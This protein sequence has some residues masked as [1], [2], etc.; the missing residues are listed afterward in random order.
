MTAKR[1]HK[2]MKKKQT[3]VFKFPE[4]RFTKN[5]GFY[6]GLTIIVVIFFIL[7]KLLH[8]SIFSKTDWN[9][10]TL[11]AKAWWQGKYWLKENYSYLELALYKGR[12]F[13]SFPP[14][15]S[16]IIFFLIPFFGMN[17]P[18]NLLTSMYMVL[19]FVFTYKFCRNLGKKDITASFWAVFLVAG[20]NVFAHAVNGGVW[21]QAQSLSFLFSTLSLYFISKQKSKYWHLAFLAWALSVGCRP[22]QIVFVPILLYLLYQNIKKDNVKNLFFQNIFSMVKFSLSP[23]LVGIALAFYNY[24]RFNNPI[25]FGHTYLKEFIE[26]PKGQ[27]NLSYLFENW[28]NIFRLPKIVGGKV[29]FER[30]NGW[31]FYLANPLYILFFLQLVKKIITRPNDVP[32]LVETRIGKQIFLQSKNLLLNRSVIRKISLFDILIFVVLLFHIVVTLMHKTLGGWQFGIR[33][34]A[35][36][37]PFILFYMMYKKDTTGSPFEEKIQVTEATL[38]IIIALIAIALNFYGCLWLFKNWS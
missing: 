12:V 18:D 27:F 6:M 3:S 23:L 30:F 19:S 33:Y 5:I 1:I 34:L 16:V 4:N 21:F 22:L 29:I 32:H 28:H 14:I 10:Y 9:S 13:V 24:L 37:L 15:P 31:A 20:N 7:Y 2:K 36:G 11:Q 8:Q 35:D 26:A 17:V 25:E 38:N